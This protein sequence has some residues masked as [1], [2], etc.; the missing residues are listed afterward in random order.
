MPE[1]GLISKAMQRLSVAMVGLLL[2]LQ[3]IVAF[4]LDVL[5]LDRATTSREWWGLAFSLAGIFLA[6]LKGRTRLPEQPI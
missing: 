4:L 2:L 5:L 6:S 3:P 1:L